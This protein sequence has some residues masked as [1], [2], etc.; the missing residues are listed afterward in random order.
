MR[1]SL[2]SNGMVLPSPMSHILRTILSLIARL[3]NLK[4]PTITRVESLNE[5][6]SR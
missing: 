6:L 3:V 4:Q 1:L 2:E 5:K